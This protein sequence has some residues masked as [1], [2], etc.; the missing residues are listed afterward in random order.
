MPPRS[1]KG[2]YDEDDF[3]DGY[4]DYDYDDYDEPGYGGALAAHLPAQQ[5]PRRAC[6]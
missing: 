1:A 4:D 3:D 6:E 2:H 5:R